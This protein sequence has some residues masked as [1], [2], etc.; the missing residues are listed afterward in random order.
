MDVGEARA[1]ATVFYVIVY[2]DA[3]KYKQRTSW[4]SYRSVIT[5]Q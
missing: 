5:K 2:E 1:P 4:V 3:I